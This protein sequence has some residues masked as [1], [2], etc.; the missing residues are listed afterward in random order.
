M[1]P[2]AKKQKLITSS[3]IASP[4]SLKEEQQEEKQKVCV[5]KA[6]NKQNDVAMFL[7]GKVISAVARNSNFVFSP[8]SIFSVLTMVAASPV[9]EILRSFI[10]SLLR[11]SS[12]DELF[13]V[14]HEVATVV[15]ADGSESGLRSVRSDRD[16]IYGNALYFKGAWE[17]K[18]PKYLTRDKE[19]HLLN[20]TSVSVPFMSNSRMQYVKVYDDFKVLKLP[21]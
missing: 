12:I 16:M 15:L 9:V 10:F 18:F 20:G 13:A 17:H 14:F 2:E 7:T 6:M 19:F 8:A 5:V 3:E 1:D 11:A 4:L 21:F